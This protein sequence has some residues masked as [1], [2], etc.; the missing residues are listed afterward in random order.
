MQAV[1]TVP[2]VAKRLSLNQNKVHQLRK[3]G[4]LRFMKLGAWKTTESE[5]D[6]FCDWCIGKDLSDPEHPKDLVTGEIVMPR[7]GIAL[8]AGATP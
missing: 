6:R 7:P 5:F 2:E 8:P 1:L 3:A 4:L